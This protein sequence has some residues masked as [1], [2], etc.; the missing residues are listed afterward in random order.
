MTIIIALDLSLTVTYLSNLIFFSRES[1]CG[2]YHPDSLSPLPNPKTANQSWSGEDRI[3]TIIKVVRATDLVMLL[4]WYQHIGNALRLLSTLPTC[5]GGQDLG[6]ITWQV[7]LS[8]S[9]GTNAHEFSLVKPF[10]F[11]AADCIS[12]SEEC[13]VGCLYA[14]GL[15]RFGHDNYHE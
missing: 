3:L 6:E 2:T 13:R 4:N 7:I 14:K 9:Y 15:L 11:I 5:R 8:G 10:E 12:A 1:R